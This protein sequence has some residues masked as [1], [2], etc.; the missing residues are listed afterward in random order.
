MIARRPFR[1]A[2]HYRWMLLVLLLAAASCCAVWRWYA[3]QAQRLERDRSIHEALRVS[4]TNPS[5]NQTHKS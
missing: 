1:M 2:P 4:A 3:V 5:S